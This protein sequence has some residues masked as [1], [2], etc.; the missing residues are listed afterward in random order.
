MRTPILAVV[1]GLSLAGCLTIGDSGSSST[2]GGG[3]DG[4]GSGSDPQG[5]GSNPST[6]KVDVT[7][8][9]P[10]IDTELY[11]NN[12][13]NVTVT[14]S[15]GFSGPVTLS[16]S[17]VDTTGTAISGW[18]VAFSPPSVTLTQNGTST[19]V[20]TLTIPGT[21]T[22]MLTGMLKVTGASSATTG[23]NTAQAPV[24][25]KN[26]VTFS[27]KVDNATGK[28]VYTQ[29][30]GTVASPVKISQGTLVRFFNTGTANLV[31]HSGGI[32]SHQGQ[33]PNG[34][35]DPVT[36]PG[37]AYEQTPTGTGAAT[38]YC[39]DPATDIGANDPRF[40]VN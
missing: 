18:T 3:D 16:G 1:L 40:S 6:A 34:L 24:T 12:P 30:S 20:A 5:S 11:T 2:G 25:L 31:I 39:H 27:V 23:S 7:V 8:D 29:E 13:I 38:W 21:N 33:A 37:T 36:E 22:G 4:S 26:Q 14:G 15:G 17:V 35:A 32:I 19:S 10:S 9:K 28:C